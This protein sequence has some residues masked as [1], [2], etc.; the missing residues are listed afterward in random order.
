VGWGGGFSECTVVVITEDEI[1]GF[2]PS[3]C[4]GGGFQW[5][6]GRMLLLKCCWREERGGCCVNEMLLCIYSSAQR[7]A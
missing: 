5:F 7:S 6:R 3:I 2:K 1:P 4:G